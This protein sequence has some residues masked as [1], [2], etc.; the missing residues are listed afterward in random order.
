MFQNGSIAA[1]KLIAKI[2][3]FGQPQHRKITKVS[4][5]FDFDFVLSF[6]FLRY[7]SYFSHWTQI[8]K[9]SRWYRKKPGKIVRFLACN[10]MDIGW[11]PRRTHWHFQATM[12]RLFNTHTHTTDS[13]VTLI[14]IRAHCFLCGFVQNG[15]T[16]TFDIGLHQQ[17]FTWA[18]SLIGLYILIECKI[19]VSSL[20]KWSFRK[21]IW[22]VSLKWNSYTC[23]GLN[24]V[25]R[26][27][28]TH[29]AYPLVLAVRR[30]SSIDGF[31]GSY[32]IVFNE[33]NRIERHVQRISLKW[34]MFSK[35]FVQIVRIAE[36]TFFDDPHLRYRIRPK[37]WEKLMKN[38]SLLE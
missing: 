25:R 15:N 36:K 2:N 34:N 6:V 3:E 10:T 38:H 4:F 5:H 1:S 17:S 14:I 28:T 27:C 21:R 19:T 33:S 32:A 16:A 22:R 37:E 35:D 9:T 29:P 30:N 8:R 7:P 13:E 31:H 12:W 26:N 20:N 11:P 24:C 23:F 18:P